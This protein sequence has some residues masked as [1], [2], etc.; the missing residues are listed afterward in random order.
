M[1]CLDLAENPFSLGKFSYVSDFG[2]GSILIIMMFKED[3][4][5]EL[6][7]SSLRRCCKESSVCACWEHRGSAACNND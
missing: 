1:V 7:K 6:H 5:N 3:V 2:G 4:L